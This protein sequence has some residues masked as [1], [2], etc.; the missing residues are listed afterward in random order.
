[1]SIK[2]ILLKLR[3]LLIPLPNDQYV[4]DQRRRALRWIVKTSH[5]LPSV[6]EALA[7]LLTGTNVH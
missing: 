1:M 6:R 7:S 3:S 4:T 2:S 5:H